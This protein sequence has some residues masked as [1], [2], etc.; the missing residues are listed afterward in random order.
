MRCGMLL[1]SKQD[2]TLRYAQK[3]HILHGQRQGNETSDYVLESLHSSFHSFFPSGLWMKDTM[4]NRFLSIYGLHRIFQLC[5]S[6]LTAHCV[7]CPYSAWAWN[8][9]NMVTR[10][11]DKSPKTGSHFMNFL[12]PRRLL[13]VHYCLWTA[14]LSA[15]VFCCQNRTLH[16]LLSPISVS[17]WC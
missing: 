5:V 15:P 4:L 14:D 16:W 17:E 11:S 6:L 8:I 12:L 7:W 2:L 13:R 1:Q 3:S 10:T 9:D